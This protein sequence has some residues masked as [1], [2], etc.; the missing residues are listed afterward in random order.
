MKDFDGV[1]LPAE[2]CFFRR[3]LIWFKLISHEQLA[4]IVNETKQDI[5]FLKSTDINVD[6][7]I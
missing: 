7:T 1:A 3:E 6:D 4:F 2:L 5:T